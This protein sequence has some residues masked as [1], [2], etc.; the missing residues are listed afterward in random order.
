VVLSAFTLISWALRPASRR[1]PRAATTERHVEAW[2]V[3]VVTV[4]AMLV[5]AF[6]TLPKGA[7]PR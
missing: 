5:V 1:L 7:P 6:F 4:A 2:V 3:P